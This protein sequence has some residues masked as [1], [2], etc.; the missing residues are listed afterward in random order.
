MEQASPRSFG[1]PDRLDY[2]KDAQLEK[3]TEFAE[4]VRRWNGKGCQMNGHLG[5]GFGTGFIKC[6]KLLPIWNCQTTL[7]SF[8]TCFGAFRMGD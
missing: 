5:E 1:S 4:T 6:Q 3:P 2:I 7:G 8:F